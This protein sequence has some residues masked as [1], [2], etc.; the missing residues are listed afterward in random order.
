M[1]ISC[2]H[3]LIMMVVM[4]LPLVVMVDITSLERYGVWD[5]ASGM[6]VGIF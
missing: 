2:V 3:W 4:L 1:L 5:E 6:V